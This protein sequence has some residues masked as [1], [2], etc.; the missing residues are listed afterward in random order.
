[1]RSGGGVN[2]VT[3]RLAFD[4]LCFG[5]FAIFA[6]SRQAMEEN[7]WRSLSRREGRTFKRGEKYCRQKVV[8]ANDRVRRI[9]K[10]VNQ[11][12]L[13]QRFVR[14]NRGEKEKNTNKIQTKCVKAGM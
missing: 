14:R 11:S 7:T 9:I 13:Y 8:E 12:Y 6:G 4:V 1:M 10:K 5:F 3:I 2:L